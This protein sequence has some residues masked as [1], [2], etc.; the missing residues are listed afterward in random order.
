MGEDAWKELMDNLEA[1]IPVYD[2]VN[3][4]VTL[5]QD[6]RWRSNV[7]GFIEPGMKV[8]EVGCGP[9]TF[10]EN[11]QG[12]D[13][14]CLDPSEAMLVWARRQG[15]GLPDLRKWLEVECIKRALLE[16]GGNITRAAAVLDMKRPRLSQIINANPEL[17][18]LKASLISA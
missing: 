4:I 7:A 10:S 16:T 18:E 11:L 15:M 2:K 8:L 3:S 12:I 1:T 5:G 17:S 6:K 14:T 13:L 9:G